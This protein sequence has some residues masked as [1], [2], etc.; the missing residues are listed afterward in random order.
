MSIGQR[1]VTIP[2]L[3]VS[4]MTYA[5]QHLDAYPHGTLLK[6][7]RHA[8]A[9]GRGERTWEMMDGQLLLTY[10]LKPTDADDTRTS[11]VEA[12]PS[13]GG[14]ASL[15]RRPRLDRG[16]IHLHHLFMAL[17]VA[18]TKAL[19]TATSCKVKW[20]NDIVC[21]RKKLAGML[22]EPVWRGTELAGV[23][24]GLGVNVN[25]RF[26]GGH[27][28]RTIATS[29]GEQKEAFSDLYALEALIS[30]HLSHWYMLW[31]QGKYEDIFSAWI[32]QLA[33]RGETLTVHRH[34]GSSI[35]GI[36]AYIKPNG[37]LVLECDSVEEEILFTQAQS[38]E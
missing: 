26:D 12:T 23:I 17:T 22:L 3:S 20:P 33:F 14:Q 6:A 24:F 13:F 31:E 11:L 8:F 16:P 15:P 32:N 36:F 38:I 10:V 4:S 25:N 30:D 34:D 37:N 29:I 7:T 27:P 9:R 5:K 18:V 2:S 1:I 35:T 28:L 19:Q 21:G